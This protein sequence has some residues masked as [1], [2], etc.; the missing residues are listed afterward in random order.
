MSQRPPLRLV[1]RN[2]D[3]TAREAAAKVGVSLRTAQRWSSEPRENYLARADEKRERVRALRQ[4][5]IHP[6]HR[7]RDRL[8]GRHRPPLRQRSPG[9]L[10]VLTGDV[11]RAAT[12][13]AVV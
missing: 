8:L 3:L 7:Q 9:R 6:S 5:S 2:P 1:K 11:D 10:A 12:G 13:V 4:R